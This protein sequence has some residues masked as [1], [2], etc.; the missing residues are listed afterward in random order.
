MFSGFHWINTPW[1]VS[2]YQP[3]V[4]ELQCW[5]DKSAL[6]SEPPGKLIKWTTGWNKPLWADSN[7][8]IIWLLG[9]HSV[10]SSSL[11]LGSSVH[12][13]LQARTL[14]WVAL[15]LA[16]DLPDTGIHAGFES[17]SL[18]SPALASRFFTASATWM[19]WFQH[20]S[21]CS[22]FCRADV[23]V[24]ETSSRGFVHKTKDFRL[25]AVEYVRQAL[26]S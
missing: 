16:G 11:Q 26:L 24:K 18:A 19:S 22:F 25:F 20:S 8:P 6:P 12:G 1:P 5:G 10:V 17:A 23:T 13:I 7:T 15:P 3:D 2:S 9:V 21:S 14:E 4:T